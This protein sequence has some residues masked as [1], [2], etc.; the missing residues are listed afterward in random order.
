MVVKVPKGLDLS[1]ASWL[2]MKDQREPAKCSAE[3]VPKAVQDW[4]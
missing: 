4:S 3:F 1:F 2:K